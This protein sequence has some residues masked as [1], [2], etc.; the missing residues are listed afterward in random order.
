MNRSMKLK[1]VYLE[2]M[3]AADFDYATEIRIDYRT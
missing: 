2:V 1:F 3:Y